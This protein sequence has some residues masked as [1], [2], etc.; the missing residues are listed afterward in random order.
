MP[1]ITS[2]LAADGFLTGLRQLRNEGLIGEVSLGMNSN[3]PQTK[4]SILRLLRESPPGTFNSALL[5]GGW[6]LL[7]QDSYE[8]MLEAQE[9]G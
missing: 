4:T 8:V 2:A 9:R 7:N 6:N 1:I 3:I 5:A